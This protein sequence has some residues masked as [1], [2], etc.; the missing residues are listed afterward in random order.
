[1]IDIAVLWGRFYCMSKQTDVTFFNPEEFVP[2]LR[3][4][5]EKCPMDL[6]K[7][8]LVPLQMD[9]AIKRQAPVPRIADRHK[10]IILQG[11]T[12]WSWEL[13]SLRSLFRG[14]KQPPHLGDYP[15]AY[16]E[17]FTLLDLHALQFGDV[18]GDPRDKEMEE[19]YSAL[20]RR[21]D[22]RSLGLLHDYMWQAA[23]W[24]LGTRV[25]S[26]AEFEAIIARLEKSCRTF[27]MGPTSRNYIESMRNIYEPA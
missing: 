19:I 14:D 9:E 13:A 20:R 1:M 17:V 12:T 7:A 25:L 27:Q 10:L 23:A 18:M 24:V 26:Q 21:P 16:N 3:A 4:E 5:Y 15:E 2:E 11:E 22:G 8:I 6:D